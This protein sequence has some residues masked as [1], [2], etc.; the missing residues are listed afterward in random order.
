MRRDRLRPALVELP[1]RYSERRLSRLRGQRARSPR[2]A[3]ELVAQ[4]GDESRRCSAASGSRSASRRQT[5]IL[6]TASPIWR[7][8]SWCRR[9]TRR[10]STTRRPA[11]RRRS[12]SWSSPTRSCWSFA[13]TTQLLDDELA[14]IYAQL[15]RPRWYDQ[16]IGSRY[17]RAARQVHSLFIDV[18]E[19]TDR[20]ENALKFIGDIYAAR[21]F[22]LVA[23]RLGLDTLESQHRSKL[24]TLDDIY[25]F[26][27][28]QSSMSRGQF[29]E[30][31]VVSDPR[32]RAAPRV[33]GRDEVTDGP[34]F[35]PW[36]S[37][38][39]RSSRSLARAP[40]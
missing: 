1:R 36:R 15:Q 18:N 39:S 19:L 22:A 38:G 17:T 8:T 11:R 26:A 29:L 40:A 2:S 5:T 25:R 24:K 9:G 10:S 35:N 12:R 30:L 4:H 23:D 3:D 6:G 13:T 37:S 7:T 21:L 20:T 33:H 31:T 27:V 28:E 34:C 16:W 32:P 14:A